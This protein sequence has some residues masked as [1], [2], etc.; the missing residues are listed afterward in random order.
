VNGQRFIS[1]PVP[2]APQPCSPWLRLAHDFPVEDS[3]RLFAQPCL[4]DHALHYFREGS[5]SYELRGETVPIRPGMLFFVRPGEGYRFTLDPGVRVR[6]YNLHFDL[7]ENERSYRPFPVPPEACRNQEKYPETLPPYQQLANHPA[8]EQCFLRLLDAASRIGVEAELERKSELLKL[9]AVLHRN[10]S[11]SPGRATGE[12]HR[13]AVEAAIAELSKHLSGNIRISEL[14]SRVGV[15]RA[16]L[17]RIFREATGE[18]IQRYFVER[19]LQ[20]AKSDLLYSR[21]EI[22]EIAAKYGFADVPHFT[23]RFRQITGTTPGQIRKK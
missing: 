5:G 20:A 1:T 23:R 4:G 11:L 3:V 9:F 14:A 21:L 22:K 17:C 7:R 8:Y 16:L 6:M 18:S 2:A 15:S 12:F 19:K 13:R 10:L